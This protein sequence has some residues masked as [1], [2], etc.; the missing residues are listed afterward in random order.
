MYGEVEPVDWHSASSECEAILG[1]SNG[2]LATVHT[3]DV[4]IN[5]ILNTAGAN[6]YVFFKREL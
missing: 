3:E 1:D 6:R 4:Q 5:R 2:M